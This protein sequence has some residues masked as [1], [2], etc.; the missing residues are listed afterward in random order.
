MGDGAMSMPAALY[1]VAVLRFDAP[2]RQATATGHRLA[3]ARA[4][5]RHE[6]PPPTRVPGTLVRSLLRGMHVEMSGRRQAVHA[7]QA[8]CWLAR[9]NAGGVCT[10][11]SRA[12]GAARIALAGCIAR[13][14]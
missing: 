1:R 12:S 3:E 11:C 14:L 7:G 9:G 10:A 13:R 6:V 8:G 5:L 2:R 4:L